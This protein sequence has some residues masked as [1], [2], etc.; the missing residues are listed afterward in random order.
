MVIGHL[1]LGFFEGGEF[2][3][4]GG[5][6]GAGGGVA[7]FLMTGYGSMI[8]HFWVRSCVM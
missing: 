3:E 8:A 5:V 6:S 2:G 1:G 4:V 7:G